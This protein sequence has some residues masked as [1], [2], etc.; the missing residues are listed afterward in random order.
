[1]S[2]PLKIERRTFSKSGELTMDFSKEIVALLPP[3]FLVE[4]GQTPTTVLETDIKRK[5]TA[6]VPAVVT[7]TMGVGVFFIS[8]SSLSREFVCVCED[9]DA[10]LDKNGLAQALLRFFIGGVLGRSVFVDAVVV[11]VIAVLVEVLLVDIFLAT[12]LPLG[13]L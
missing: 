10:F 12:S 9:T 8:S 5:D 13:E 1:M 3:R 4:R 2:Y 11:F 6:W 7:R